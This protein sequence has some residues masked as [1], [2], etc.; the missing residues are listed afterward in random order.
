MGIDNPKRTRHEWLICIRTIV[1][2]LAEVDPGRYTQAAIVRKLVAIGHKV[3][4]ALLNQVARGGTAS[5]PYLKRMGTGLETILQQELGRRYDITTQTIVTERKADWSPSYIAEA[6]E[7]ESSGFIFHANGRRTKAEKVAFMADA[8]KSVTFIGIKMRQLANYFEGH[9]E[10]EFTAHILGLLTR[11]VDV[12]CFLIDPDCQP[13]HVYF[14]ELAKLSEVATDNE[15]ILRNSIRILRE[16]EN[17]FAALD[18][19][20]DF[21]VHTYRRLP[22]AHF[23][24]V[25][26]DQP[27]GRMHVAHYLPGQPNRRAPVIEVWRRTYAE[28]YDLYRAVADTI[29]T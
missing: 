13:A 28:L 10:D 1:T 3:S 15:A 22:T 18:L 29:I 24:I 6:D 4:A 8:R 5:L 19:R 7:K 14:Y 26:G 9:R 21:R 12:D 25:D 27:D 20:G 16:Q 23:L 17:R 2:H 11:G